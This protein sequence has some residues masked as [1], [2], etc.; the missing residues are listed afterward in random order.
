[1]RDLLRLAHPMPPTA[2]HQELFYWLTRGWPG[3]G[4]EPH[5]DAVLRRIWAL[6]RAKRAERVEEV[7]R[8]IREE[9]LPRE[10]VPTR[11]LAQPAVW[12]ALLNDMPMTALVRNLA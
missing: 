10:A 1:H 11:W 2:Q 3:V 9:R 8:L 6:E 5:P 12:E 4:D 7:V